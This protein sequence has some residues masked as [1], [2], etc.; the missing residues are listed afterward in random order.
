M[1]ADLTLVDF[2]TEMPRAL[3]AHGLSELV[4]E[5]TVPTPYGPDG[6][7]DD[8]CKAGLEENLIRCV[9]SFGCVKRF[10]IES[11]D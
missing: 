5:L 6:D 4:R 7:E 11:A 3:R 1:V 10:R 8:S 9:P 2:S